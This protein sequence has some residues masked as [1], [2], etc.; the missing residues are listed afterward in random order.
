MSEQFNVTVNLT[1]SV[2]SE[3]GVVYALPCHFRETRLEDHATFYCPN[4]H[5][6]HFPG[7]STEEE[8]EEE[9]GELIEENLKLAASLK[10][11]RNKANKAKK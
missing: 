6:Q 8:R 2:C 10:Y 9:T 11:Y 7:K 5:R 1:T 4:G 3:C